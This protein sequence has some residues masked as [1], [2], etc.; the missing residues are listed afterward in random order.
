MEHAPGHSKDG[1]NWVFRYDMS[2]DDLDVQAE[3]QAL[4]ARNS[5]FRAH[6]GELAVM[7]ELYYTTLF[8]WPVVTFGWEPFMLAATSDPE[9]FDR[10]LWGPW[11]HISRRHFKALAAI[12]EEVIFC[13]D[14]LG[15]GTGPIF[16]PRFYERYIFSRYEW[17]MEP[18]VRAGKRIVFVSDG[19]ID[20]FLE[21]LL[22][23]PIS[24]I[25]FES[26]T[27]PLERV[28]DTWGRAGRGFI[29][30]IATVVLTF[31][32]PEQVR[33]H[34]RQV[35]RRGQ[36]YPGFIISSCGGLPANIPLAN[37]LA[38]FA[39]R[40]ELGIAAELQGAQSAGLSDTGCGRRTPRRLRVARRDERMLDSEVE[41][42]AD[43]PLAVGVQCVDAGDLVARLI[44]V[45]Q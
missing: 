42:A 5:A 33:E 13:H 23:L 27:T 8:M 15:M 43:Q 12:D 14:D 31:G 38:Y 22:E 37:I 44:H 20:A 18:A 30:G 6:F 25:M 32:T 4:R 19:N 24:G 2:A 39:V 26:P 29:G 35:I 3:A 21:R 7:Y 40:N 41:K 28:L 10:E 16:S 34:T 1:D 45:D 9:R 11:S 17:I 36:E